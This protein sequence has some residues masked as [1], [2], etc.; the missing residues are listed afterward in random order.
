MKN[1][2][3]QLP[4]HGLVFVNIFMSRDRNVLDI[5]FSGWNFEKA[6]RFEELERVCR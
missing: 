5:L 1:F 4:Q 6:S 3:K 2:V